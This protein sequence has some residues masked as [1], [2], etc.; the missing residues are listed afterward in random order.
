MRHSAAPLRDWSCATDGIAEICTAGFEA[1]ANTAV[2]CVTMT[3]A[4]CAS[5][6][7]ASAA[8]PHTAACGCWCC[9]ALSEPLDTSFSGFP[10]ISQP[11][12]GVCICDTH[13]TS[14]WNHEIG[15]ARLLTKDDPRGKGRD[16]ESDAGA[17]A[18]QPILLPELASFPF[19]GR[20]GEGVPARMNQ[21]EAPRSAVAEIAAPVRRR[22]RADGK[23]L[24]KLWAAP[25]FFWI[26]IA[27]GNTISTRRFCGSRTPSAV[28]TRWSFLPRPLT[29]ML[30]RGTPNRTRALATLFARRSESRWL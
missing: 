3:A 2:G 29:T 12:R 8:D 10:R 1:V 25:A 20:R 4:A 14:V 23:P 24:S 21:S 7:P 13:Q 18:S 17:I 6:A 19:G 26:E 16:Q 22:G 27:Y 11:S 30:C 28:G 15:S 5:S 9:R